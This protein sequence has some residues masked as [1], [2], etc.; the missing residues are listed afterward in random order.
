VVLD[1]DAIGHALLDQRPA[2]DEVLA[3]FGETILDRSAGGDGPPRIDRRALGA[4]VFEHAGSLRDLERILHPRMRGTFERAIAR[5]AR[6]GQARAVVLDA[7]ILFEAGWNDLCD[8]VVFVDA[9]EDQRRA[10]LAAQRGWGPEV[11]AARE[12]AQ[13]PLDR[14]RT[15]ADF[16]LRND[17]APEALH[18]E[19]QRLWGQVTQAPSPARPPRPSRAGPARR[20]RTPRPPRRG[21]MNLPDPRA[22]LR[23]DRPVAHRPRSSLT[24]GTEPESR[25]PSHRDLIP[26]HRRGRPGAEAAPP[27]CRA[28]ASARSGRR[29]SGPSPSRFLCPS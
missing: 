20:G 14:K 29:V 28:P 9:P 4:L 6:K 15:A 18:E 10:R 5:A 22:G 27:L 13:W 25:S 12:R 23:A 7:A 2:R 16:I 3:R 24:D 1:A 11:L 19:A 17:A 21:E 8:R 26:P